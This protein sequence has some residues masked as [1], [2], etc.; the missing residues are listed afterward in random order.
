M[1]TYDFVK[2]GIKNQGAAVLIDWSSELKDDCSKFIAIEWL[3][4]IDER[5]KIVNRSISLS[6]MY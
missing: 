2:Y 5:M 1:K 3:V 4:D 6:K